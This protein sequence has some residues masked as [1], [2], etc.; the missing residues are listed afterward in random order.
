MS[1]GWTGIHGANILALWWHTAFV[2]SSGCVV[3]LSLLADHHPLF[4]LSAN[5]AVGAL[6]WSVLFALRLLFHS[7]KRIGPTLDRVLHHALCSVFFSGKTATFSEA[8]GCFVWRRPMASAICSSCADISD[9]IFVNFSCLSSATDLA[10]SGIVFS[11]LRRLFARQVCAM[12]DHH[13]RL[14]VL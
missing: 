13:A 14:N 10:L 1:G 8:A 9:S 4:R 11:H 5:T 6:S 7:Q 3:R 12:N 2:T